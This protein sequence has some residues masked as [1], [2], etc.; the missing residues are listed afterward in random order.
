MIYIQES[1][2][3]SRAPCSSPQVLKSHD[4]GKA[5]PRLPKVNICRVSTTKKSCESLFRVREG[6]GTETIQS[7]STKIL[8]CKCV[9][10]IGD[11][12]KN[13]TVYVQKS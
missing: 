10:N 11:V 8:E 9:Y 13:V 6:L 12:N 4:F 5:A 7:Q 3:V 2:A 1:I